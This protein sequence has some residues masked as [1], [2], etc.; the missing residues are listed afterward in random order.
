MIKRFSSVA[1]VFLLLSTSACTTFIQQQDHQMVAEP[2]PIA[3]RLASAVDKATSALQTLASVEQAR[4]PSATV[5]M[6]PGAPQELR[7]TMSVEWTGPI[8]TITQRVAARAGYSFNVSGD[9]P[10]APVIVDISAVEKPVIELLRDIGLQAG[11]RANIVVNADAKT[12][13]VSYAPVTS[14]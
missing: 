1:C 6:A 2:D 14:G 7:R 13:E 5:E 4:T 3:L 10:P 12:I 9:R 11:S 8:E